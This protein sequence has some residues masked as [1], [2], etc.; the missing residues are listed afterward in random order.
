MLVFTNFPNVVMLLKTMSF[1]DE[2]NYIYDLFEKISLKVS[3]LLN[4]AFCARQSDKAK[5]AFHS[6][7][8]HDTENINANNIQKKLC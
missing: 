7:H 3:S 5:R 4:G 2:R 6:V 1:Y 8:F